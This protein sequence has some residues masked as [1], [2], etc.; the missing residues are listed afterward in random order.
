MC[1]AVKHAQ[2]TK[3]TNEVGEEPCGEHLSL[4]QRARS[5]YTACLLRKQIYEHSFYILHR[6]Q[7]SMP[8]RQTLSAISAKGVR[9]IVKRVFNVFAFT[10]L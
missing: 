6:V 10:F 2:Y 3:I 4:A 8:K 5:K 1:I 7:G 9:V